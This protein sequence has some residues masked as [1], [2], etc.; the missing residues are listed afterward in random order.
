LSTND[1]LTAIQNNSFARAITKSNHL[2]I[3]ALQIVHVVGLVLLL[4]SL[5]LMSLRLL[6]LVL[7]EQPAVRVTR[8]LAI[9]LRSGL[10]LTVIS[11]C[12][13]FLTGPRHY[14]YNSAFELKMGLLLAA[15]TVQFT[16]FRRIVA[17]NPRH[18][19]VA[20]LA[21]VLSLLLWFGVSIAGRAIGFV[22]G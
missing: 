22:R 4:A 5:V 14:F 11:G 12:L 7:T 15:V 9:L 20:K 18:P 6:G 21:V 17:I 19:L 2:V 16:L 13:M 10:A 3:A 1:I 8:E